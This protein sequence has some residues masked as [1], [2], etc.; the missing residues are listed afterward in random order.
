MRK[1]VLLVGGT[2]ALC[3]ASTGEKKP[4]ISDTDYGR[5][6][7]DQT[8]VVETARQNEMAAKD[9]VARASLRTKNAG[10]EVQRAQ[11]ETSAVDA[12]KKK[13][14]VDYKAASDSRDTGALDRAN[15]EKQ[16]AALHEQTN[17]AHIDYANKLQAAAQAEEKAAQAR[18]DTATAK[19]DQAK[20]QALKKSNVPAAGKYDTN[21]FDQAVNDATARQ[22]QAES[23]AQI[24]QRQAN[25]AEREWT[26]LNDQFKART[27]LH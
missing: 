12:N 23:E 19:V 18:L 2:L 27:G 6:T 4:Q 11:A 16:T 13:A 17:K 24:A 22:T 3:C 9:E 15:S 7:A 26:D 10:T 1:L 25:T 20:L 21:Q 14:D 5:L 8:A